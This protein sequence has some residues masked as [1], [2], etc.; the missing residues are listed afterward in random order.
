M[1]KR[2]DEPL[3]Q[4]KWVLTAKTLKQISNGVTIRDENTAQ[5]HGAYYIFN[6]DNTL[7]EKTLDGNTFTM[8]Y[9]L[10]G[11]SLTFIHIENKQNYGAK[12]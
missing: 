12:E 7:E 5:F 9:T 4:G 3:I 1:R 10:V 11:D 2:N 6:G 8:Q